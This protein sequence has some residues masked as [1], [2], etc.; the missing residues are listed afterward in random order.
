MSIHLRYLK[1]GSR[2][3]DVRLRHPRTG[4]EY[5]RTFRTKKEAEGFE[6]RER[7]DRSRGVWHD[8]RRAEVPFE[9]WVR[10]WQARRTAR[11]RTKKR[12]ADLIDGHLLPALGDRPLGSITPLDVQELVDSWGEHFTPSTVRTYHA[13]LKAILNAAVDAEAIGR[14]PCRTTRLPKLE[15]PRKH[16][17]EP[18]ELRRLAEALPVAYRPMV[19]VAAETG[20]RWAEAAALRVRSLDLPAMTLT[21]SEQIT[22]VGGRLQFTA[23][24][25]AASFRT[26]AISEPLASLLG[27]H[28]VRQGLTAADTDALLFTAPNGGPLRYSHF[29]SRV[30][31]PATKA[32]GLKGVTFH[33][34]R[35][36][37]ASST[38]AEG[39]GIKA[40]QERGGWAT[41]RMLLDVYAK[42]LPGADQEAAKRL[43]ARFLTG[44]NGL[45]NE[46][47]HSPIERP[48]E[49]PRRR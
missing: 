15:R 25:T 26:V 11:P 37:M 14:N 44:Q 7:A 20:T 28:L 8:P 10:Q 31:T 30:W 41:S 17:L 48:D 36:T 12:D 45:E 9:E 33:D 47:T 34:L 40:A 5:S 3:Y 35:R 21:I 18:E 27:E 38:L 32:A 49:V 43:G 2:R 19:Y 6:A 4:K 24:K 42:A 23:P 29:R 1:D 46:D 13:V 16:P 22:E 39:V